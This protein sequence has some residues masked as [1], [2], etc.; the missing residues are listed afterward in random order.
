MVTKNIITYKKIYFLPLFI[1]F[2]CLF[3]IKYFQHIYFD[4]IN[5]NKIYFYDF[6]FE[7]P[8]KYA[9]IPIPADAQIVT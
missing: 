1:T 8:T 3:K 5:G 7:L 4:T 2:P 9:I 6:S